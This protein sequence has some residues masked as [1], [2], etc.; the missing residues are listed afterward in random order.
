MNYPAASSGVSSK[1]L[2]APRGGEYNPCPP[3]AD[4]KMTLRIYKYIFCLF[5]TSLLVIFYSRINQAQDNQKTYS[6]S[7]GKAVEIGKDIYKVDDKKVL[8]EKYVVRKGDYVWKILRQKGL[9][10]EK[11]NLFELLSVLKKLNR[12]LHNLDLVHPGEKIIIP[13][14]IMPPSGA[15][16]RKTPSTKKTISVALLKDLRFQNYT[17]KPGDCLIK[18]IKG[19][20]NIPQKDWDN[21]YFELIKKINPSIKDLD[22]IFPGQIIKL[23]IYSPEII[24]KPTEPVISVKS[25]DTDTIVHNIGSIFSEMGEEWVH[26]GEHF[27]P[28]K[29]GGQI[30]L[31]AKSFPIINLKDGLRVIVDLDNKFP[32]KTDKIIESSWGNYRIVHLVDD[33]FRSAIDKILMACNYPKVLKSGEPFELKGDISLKITGD[34]IVTNSETKSDNRPRIFVIYLTDT[35]TSPTPPMIKDYLDGLGIKVID[36]PLGDDDTSN[37]KGKMEKLE[38]GKDY[39]SLIKT[40]L[41]LTGKSF[42]AQVKIPAYQSQK[43]GFKL[44]INADFFLKIKGKN[45]IIDMTGL[46]PEIIS[47]LKEHQFLVLSLAG[48]KDPLAMIIKTLGFL[49]V[50]FDPGPHHFMATTR[51]DSRNIQLTLPGIIFSDNRGK[52]ILATKLNI[53]D[54]IAAFL[55]EKGYCILDLSSF[56]PAKHTEPQGS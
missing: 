40:V 55:S 31:N 47:F 28:L 30:E 25:E 36:Y 32:D 22:I 15:S 12:T 43:T 33:N 3:L 56:P 11:K 35:D 18:I 10:K 51:D 44:I 34:W 39:S 50:Q 16:N 41:A 6:I 2:N 54:E 27:I 1:A 26:T 14:K 24:R 37:K 19:R 53:P 45:A 21:K 38:G 49:N 20:F 9:T 13:L 5:F 42:S 8:T 17:I 29:S 46:G 23:P 4:L 52:A 48:E 7:Q